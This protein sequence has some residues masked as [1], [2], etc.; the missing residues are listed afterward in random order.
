MM[1]R[2][3]STWS[4]RKDPIAIARAAQ[5]AERFRR[6]LEAPLLRTEVPDLIELSIELAEGGQGGMP[7]TRHVRRFVLAT[8]RAL[9]LIP[10]GNPLCQGGGHDIS[11]VVMGALRSHRLEQAGDSPCSGTVDAVPCTRT[12]HF[13]VR[14]TY[15]DSLVLLSPGS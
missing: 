4:S 14:G 6:E 8:A 15:E 12:V 3:R 9:F 2:H 13:V 5:S 7:E 1:T 11:T 10:C